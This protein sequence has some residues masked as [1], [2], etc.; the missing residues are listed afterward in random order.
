LAIA[1]INNILAKTEEKLQVLFDIA[2]NPS[3][4]L[5]IVVLCYSHFCLFGGMARKG[6]SEK[7]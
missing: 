2:R 7:G 3:F 4:Q 6:Q 5:T 1:G